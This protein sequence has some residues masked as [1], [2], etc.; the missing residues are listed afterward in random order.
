MIGCLM[1]RIGGCA[2]PPNAAV[3]D[4]LVTTR[5]ASHEAGTDLRKG[6]L[7]KIGAEAKLEVEVPSSRVYFSC[8]DFER[9]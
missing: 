7:L 9:P 5:G 8:F 4:L 6:F 3:S 2:S 1:D